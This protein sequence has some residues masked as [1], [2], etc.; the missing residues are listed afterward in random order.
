MER[1]Q[2]ISIAGTISI[3]I[4][5]FIFPS[6]YFYDF[7]TIAGLTFVTFGSAGFGYAMALEK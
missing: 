7:Q 6:S 1:N 2:I 5:A 4:G 3:V